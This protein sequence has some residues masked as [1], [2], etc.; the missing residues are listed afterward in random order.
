MSSY[1]E[2]AAT[3]RITSEWQLSVLLKFTG[4]EFIS[5][6]SAGFKNLKTSNFSQ[7]I[8]VNS[9]NGNKFNK[10]RS[11]QGLHNYYYC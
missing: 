11:S 10:W 6:A 2:S 3:S 1:K 4:G 8:G 7:V 5:V 9:K